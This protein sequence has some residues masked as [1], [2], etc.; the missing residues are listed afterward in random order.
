MR[1]RNPEGG[2]VSR[3]A[4]DAL[5]SVVQLPEWRPAEGAGTKIANIDQER[6]CFQAKSTHRVIRDVSIISVIA[7]GMSRPK[8]L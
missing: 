6:P 3:K 1:Y 8:C 7:I 4:E 2:G 5:V